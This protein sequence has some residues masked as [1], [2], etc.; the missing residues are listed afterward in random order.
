MHEMVFG[1]TFD[2][3]DCARCGMQFAVSDNWNMARRKSGT[4]FFWELYT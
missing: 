2:L 4:G 1:V 3:I